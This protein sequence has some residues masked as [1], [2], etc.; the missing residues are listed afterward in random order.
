MSSSISHIYQRPRTWLE[1]FHSMGWGST[2]AWLTQQI[3][4]HFI[5]GGNLVCMHGLYYSTHGGWWEW[6]PP[7]FHFRMPYWAHMIKW[8]EYTER[9]SYLLSQGTHVCDIALMYP[10][11]SMQA[12]PGANASATFGVALDLS[13]HGLDYDFMHY[14]PLRDAEADNGNLIVG[15]ESYKILILS[16]LWA[17]HHTTLTKA[18]EHY[19]NG[20][21]VLA[22]GVLPKASTLDGENSKAVNDILFELFGIKDNDLLQGIP[23]AQTNSSRGVGMY[24]RPAEMVKE[25]KNLIVPDFFSQ[26]G[27]GKVLHRKIGDKDLY[28]VTDVEKGDLCFF[29]AKGKVELW[30]AVSGKKELIPVYEENEKGTYLKMN[31]ESNQSYLIVFSPGESLK[32]TEEKT[33]ELASTI[34][35]D[36]PW[37][38]EYLPTLDNKW[39]DYRLPATDEMIGAEAPVVK[40][41]LQRNEK[42]KWYLPD[43]EDSAWRESIYGYGIQAEYCAVDST[44]NF[45]G[46]AS[47]MKS[48]SKQDWKPY[49]FSW[50]YGVWDNPG[51]QGF[52]GLKN[53]VSNGFFILNN[54]GHEFYR[55]NVWVPESGRYKVVTD[56]RKPDALLLDGETIAFENAIQLKK[57]WHSLLFGYRSTPK[58]GYQKSP[59]DNDP[60]Q[61]SMVVLYPENEVIPS[62]TKMYDA[63]VSSSW[64][65][66]NH[67]FYSPYSPSANT[68]QY[69]V[70]TVP[71]V[72]EIEMKIYGE[73]KNVW[74]DGKKIP[75]RQI[76][77][78][79]SDDQ[80]TYKISLPDVHAA[81][82]T[83]SFDVKARPGYQAAGVMASPIKFVCG[84]GQLSVGNW[85][86][87]GSLRYYSGGMYYRNNVDL[88][89]QPE[90]KVELSLGNVIATCEVKVNNQSVGILMSPP[91]AVD[92]SKY[93]K[94][95]DNAIEVLVYSTLSNL[96]QTIPSYYR[97]EPDAGLLGP[98][99]LKV[100]K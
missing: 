82:E 16:D 55:T 52:H 10:T 32:Y 47:Q 89:L 41:R 68:W 67:L 84:K 63:I 78:N 44:E 53:R 23:K 79:S 45:N 40:Y 57:G 5:A 29:R 93:L 1:A 60:R 12:Y 48:D 88:Q 86:E 75:S 7:D 98:V 74:L 31:K 26:K 76:F 69:R 56:D 97:G 46:V 30:D 24:V 28:M 13:E 39:G 2:G 61:R 21:I 72:S 77:G 51:P 58:I 94:S 27:K 42:D 33:K 37:E 25:I 4:H 11:E 54:G 71:G 90:D 35:I 99:E 70:E 64:G 17:C 3:D 95:G 87:Q 8:L 19:R 100:F 22:T 80:N 49:E 34:S 36:K 43:Y 20:G 66:S 73:L 18:L 91:Y 38:I 92:I 14:K 6:A 15:D 59:F 85:A 50:Q 83:M 65:I 9:M 81:I 96:Y 62:K